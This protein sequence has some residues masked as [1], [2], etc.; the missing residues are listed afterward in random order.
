MI[1]FDLMEARAA[2]FGRTQKTTQR[3]RALRR[4]PYASWQDDV[5]ISI[6]EWSQLQT[7]P[8]S[9]RRKC[10]KDTPREDVG[11]F[12]PMFK[13]DVRQALYEV[14]DIPVQQ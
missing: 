14:E 10:S 13:G 4:I 3:A 11:N 1:S 2:K 6:K 9:T 7:T 8:L 5:L 12:L